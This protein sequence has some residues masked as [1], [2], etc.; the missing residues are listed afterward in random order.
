MS[1]CWWMIR[2]T[3]DDTLSRSTLYTASSY[4][5]AEDDDASLPDAAENAG[6]DDERTT[7]E[8]ESPT[9]V[10]Q[11]AFEDPSTK[12]TKEA[13]PEVPLKPSLLGEK[14]SSSTIV[15]PASSP[16]GTSTTKSALKKSSSY[17]ELAARSQETSPA[18]KSTN[19]SALKKTSSYG[20]LEELGA[21]IPICSKKSA[22]KTLPPPVPTTIAANNNNNTEACAAWA[23]A[24]LFWKH[25][26]PP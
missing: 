24:R 14:P 7:S 19:K 3:E 22:W 2:T 10:V 5:A 4:G 15:A 8:E 12:L 1:F 9:C 13:L 20:E 18:G 25:L 26:P 21:D 17:G 23:R 6:K 16:S 11:V